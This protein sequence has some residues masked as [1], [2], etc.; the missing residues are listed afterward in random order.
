MKIT[1]IRDAVAPIPSAM[2][3]AAI[4]FD[5]MTISVVAIETNVTRHGKPVDRLRLLLQRALC[6][7]RCH[8]R[9]SGAAHPGG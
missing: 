3:N 5:K 9:A 4:S 1:R 6:A 7:I 8:T 2:R